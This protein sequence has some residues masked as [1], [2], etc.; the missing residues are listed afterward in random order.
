MRSAV[1]EENNI[2]IKYGYFENS[3]TKTIKTDLNT[4]AN[5]GPTLLYAREINI[6]SNKFND[7]KALCNK[8]SIPKNF[9][10]E[11]LTLKHSQ[12]IKDALNETDEEDV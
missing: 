10:N 2:T 11:Y 4:S 5:S 9:H 3:D 6:S 12:N 1:F 7:L 8:T